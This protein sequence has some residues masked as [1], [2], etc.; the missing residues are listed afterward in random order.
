MTLFGPAYF[1]AR[2]PR[3]CTQGRGAKSAEVTSTETHQNDVR[4]VTPEK[5]GGSGL[6]GIWS[7]DFHHAVHAL[8]TGERDGY[9]QDF[10][11]AEQLAKAISDVFVYDGGYSP[12]R[13]RRHGNRVGATNRSHFVV[14]IQNHDQVG[15]RALGDRLSTIVSPAANR[16]ACGLLLLSPCVPLLFMGEEY[17][18]T[19][20]FPFF[21]SFGNANLIEAVRRGRQAE[22]AGLAFQW[23][24]AIPDPQDPATFTAAKLQWSLARRRSSLKRR[25][26]ALI[27]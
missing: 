16:L 11:R 26:D 10:G 2:S 3:R 9:Y 25:A 8:L 4:L 27:V 17:G 12:F 15:N 22:F 6:D 23:K 14:A 1:A 18:E 20:P 21:C 7:D 24:Q 13:R 19:R 5:E